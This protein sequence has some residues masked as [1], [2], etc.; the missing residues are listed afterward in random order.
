MGD[1]FGIS[2]TPVIPPTTAAR[3]PLS[4]VSFLDDQAL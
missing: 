1:V 2:N 4:N 3:L